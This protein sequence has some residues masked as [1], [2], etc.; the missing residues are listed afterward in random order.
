MPG[1]YFVYILRCDNNYLYIGIAKDVQARFAQH[2]KG[3][4]AKFTRI[5]KPTAVAYSRKIGSLSKALKKEAQLKKMSRPEK[6]QLI[7]Q[8]K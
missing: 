1:N 8:I 4:G 3:K 5:N 2:Q 6:E 7:A